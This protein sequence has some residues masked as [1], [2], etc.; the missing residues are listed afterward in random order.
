MTS[1]LVAQQGWDV[2]QSGCAEEVSTPG[3]P[4]AWLGL[5]ILAPLWFQRWNPSELGT[6]TVMAILIIVSTEAVNEIETERLSW[7]QTG[8]SST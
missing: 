4:H 3:E 2:A 5:S 7:R 8:S 1:S 6:E